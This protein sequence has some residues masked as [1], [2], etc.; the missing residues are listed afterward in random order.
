MP[1]EDDCT[2]LSVDGVV[3]PKFFQTNRPMREHLDCVKALE[4]REDDVIV[5]A[6]PKSGTHWL[7]EQVC[8]LQAGKADYDRR[9][10]DLAMLEATEIERTQKAPSPRVMDTHLPVQ[11]LPRQVK[12]KRVKIVHVYRNPKDV[13]VSLYFHTKQYPTMTHFGID[14]LLDKYFFSPDVNK[15][16]NYFQY[17]KDVDAFIKA[18]P[19]IPVFNVSFEDM[20]E[21]PVKTVTRLAEFLG[22]QAT[23]ELCQQVADACVFDKLKQ[24]DRSKYQLLTVPPVEMFRK[25]VVGDWKNHLTAAEE[26]RI[27]DAMKDLEGCDF[28]FRYSL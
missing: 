14:T 3:F 11:M 27:D 22:V 10:K 15:T 24:A 8:M 5:A 20:K 9:T 12:E 21:D 16:C 18:N 19:D 4:M 7:W 25:G 26:K 2:W 13:V 28:R 17:L 23:P 6:F 1:D